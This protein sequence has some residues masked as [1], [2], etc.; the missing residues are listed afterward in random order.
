MDKKCAGRFS[1][2]I[3][4]VDCVVQLSAQPE[5]IHYAR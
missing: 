2:D 5:E 1:I 3:N 4:V